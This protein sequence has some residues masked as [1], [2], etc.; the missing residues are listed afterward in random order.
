MRRFMLCTLLL[1]S[2][3]ATYTNKIGP[4]RAS[5]SASDT[6]SIVQLA[7][8]IMGTYCGTLILNAVSPDTVWVEMFCDNAESG[9]V[10]VRRGGTWRIDKAAGFPPVPPR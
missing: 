1:L 3:C 4:Y 10:A 5:L 6:R 8:S 9:F 2:A 7:N